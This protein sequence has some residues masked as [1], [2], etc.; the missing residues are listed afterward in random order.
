MLTLREKFNNKR[1]KL[2]E[3]CNLRKMLKKL[4]I[5]FTKTLKETKNFSMQS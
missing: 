2:L 3:I 1:A 5:K 4:A